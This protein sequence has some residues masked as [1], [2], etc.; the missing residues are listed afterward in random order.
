VLLFTGIIVALLIASIASRFGWF[1]RGSTSGALERLAADR[2]YQ[3]TDDRRGF[4]AVTNGVTIEVSVGVT[5]SHGGPLT[6]CSV[7]AMA[8]EPI[9]VRMHIQPKH[10]DEPTLMRIGEID[11]DT[12]FR[13]EA[14][15]RELASDLLDPE[16]RG[17]LFAFG[18][19]GE[20]SY[21]N[22]SVEFQWEWGASV[23]TKDIDMAMAIV[24]AFC[25]A[26]RTGP[27]YRE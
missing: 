12:C 1:E 25:R 26:R 27:P 3:L 4:T 7:R 18:P 23:S 14:D 2:G 20:L 15:S 6:T 22:G 17:A 13:L 10:E 21:S 8:R 5:P 16:A 19:R 11:F 9:H 24:H